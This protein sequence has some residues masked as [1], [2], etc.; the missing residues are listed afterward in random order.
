M[1]SAYYQGMP[2]IPD[3]DTYFHGML[4]N[5]I[6]DNHRTTTSVPYEVPAIPHG[7]S[8]NFHVL[9]AQIHWVTGLS[10]L[11][12]MRWFA[13][14][15]SG[16]VALA[17][18]MITKRLVGSTVGGLFAAAL[19]LFIPLLSARLTNTFPENV[20]VLFIPVLLWL[21][22][23]ANENKDRYALYV[24]GF[25]V[26]SAIGYHFS[27]YLLVPIFLGGMILYFI[28]HRWRYR[29]ILYI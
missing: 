28:G 22:L 15:L 6:V 9:A 3:G 7:Y 17:V 13:P 5:Y 23:E 24:S 29:N 2:F 25:L 27:S 11:S 18:F 12:I 8:F 20:L 26:V 19:T 4:T 21:L 16:L 14:A 10:V 1:K